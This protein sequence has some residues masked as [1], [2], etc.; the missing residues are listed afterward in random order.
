MADSLWLDCSAKLCELSHESVNPTVWGVSIMTGSV[1]F[2]M[3]ALRLVARRYSGN[4]LWLD[5]L[6]QI[7]GAIVMIPLLAIAIMVSID[8]LGKHIY[9]IDFKQS[10]TGVF[11]YYY[12]AE[13]IYHVYS[14]LIKLCMLFLYIRIFP[15][16]LTKGLAYGGIAFLVI[17]QVVVTFL[18]IFQCRPVQAVYDLDIKQKQCLNLTNIAA[19]GTAFN[20]AAE[21]MIFFIP[22][23]VVSSLQMSRSKKVGI[24]FL[25][26]I[27]LM[28]VVL[29]SL[30][31]LLSPITATDFE[32][33]LI[34]NPPSTSTIGIASARAPTL[35]NLRDHRDITLTL[36]PTFIW[37]CAELTASNIVVTLPA[38]SKF[39]HAGFSK[40]SGSVQSWMRSSEKTSL[41]TRVIGPIT[42]RLQGKNNTLAHRLDT[43]ASFDSLGPITLTTVVSSTGGDEKWRDPPST[44]HTVG[45]NTLQG[46]QISYDDKV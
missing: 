12:L 36:A 3:L 9:D 37:S 43:M 25:F 27:G 32:R 24:I 4:K 18:T 35:T 41:A 28:W 30:S 16:R 44:S 15:D 39:L 23:P 29:L 26:S 6:F 1:C 38:V 22:I 19:S 31:G 13:V 8:G 2:A 5:D 20:I 14:T 34:Q 40:V 10:Y 7:L 46:S 33:R 11:K 42:R 45:S 17:S 21:L